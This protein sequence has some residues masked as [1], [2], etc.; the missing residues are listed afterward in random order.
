MHD[1]QRELEKTQDA[2][3]NQTADAGSK[4]TER[5]GGRGRLLRR[6]LIAAYTHTSPVIV[7]IVIILFCNLCPKRHCRRCLIRLPSCEEANS[8]RDLM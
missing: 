4:Q 8:A 2:R 7:V 5:R 3:R 1:F 6:L